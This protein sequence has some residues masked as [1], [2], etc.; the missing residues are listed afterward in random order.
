MQKIPKDKILLTCVCI[1][2]LILI[3][4]G[5]PILFSLVSDKASIIANFCEPEES[6]VI[7]QKK[8]QISP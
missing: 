6:E 5:E 2:A 8:K 1:D 3:G 7:H 4:I